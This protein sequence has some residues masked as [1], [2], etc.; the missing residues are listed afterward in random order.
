MS[1]T[2]QS[3]LTR[4]RERS[5][6]IGI[7]PLLTQ[8]SAGN[9]STKLED[10]LWIKASGKWM[11]DA[12]HEDILIPLDPAKLSA[13]NSSS[14]ETDW[15]LAKVRRRI[16]LAR[17][18]GGVAWKSSRT[19]MADRKD[20]FREIVGGQEGRQKKVNGR[21]LREPMRVP[22]LGKPEGAQKQGEIKRSRMYIVRRYNVTY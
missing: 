2:N 20:W 17:S 13:W 11:A 4:P 5:A 18:K 6:R 12:M 16:N 19:N 7:D 21:R 22:L 10:A 14:A 8:A 9:G 15:R 3:E 1:A